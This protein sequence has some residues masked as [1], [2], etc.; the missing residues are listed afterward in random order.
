M[1]GKGRQNPRHFLRGA[2]FFQRPGDVIRKEDV[3]ELKRVT[4]GSICGE[5]LGDSGIG[6]DGVR[7][8]T[9]EA[10]SVRS[11]LDAGPE[12]YGGGAADVWYDVRL[13]DDGE[14]YLVRHQ[15]SGHEVEERGLEGGAV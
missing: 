4:V 12:A 10:I 15:L 2:Y 8:K 13:T 11:W 7:I 3:R 5:V 14:G 6:P 1:S 9:R